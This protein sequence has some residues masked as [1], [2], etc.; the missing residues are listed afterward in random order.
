MEHFEQFVTEMYP[1]IRDNQ[2][3]TSIINDK[4][5]R[6]LQGYL[7]DARERGANIIEI[8]PQSEN[9]AA[10]RKMA[11]TVLT[12]VSPDMQIMQNQD[13]EAVLLES[14]RLKLADHFGV[15]VQGHHLTIRTTL[16]N[17]Y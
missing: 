4:Q 11:P 16:A 15:T 17:G 9:V 1:H 7:E 2:D 12:N 10:T 14:L 8:N 6:R 13:A 3:Y 5:Y